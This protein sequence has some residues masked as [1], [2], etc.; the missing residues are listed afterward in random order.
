MPKKATTADGQLIL[1]LYDL[2]RESEMRKA[3]AWWASKLPQSADE[4]LAVLNNF[5]A[6]ENA[7]MRQVSGYWETAAALV[8]H[9]AVNEELFFDT[10]GEMWFVYAKIKP[11]LPELRKKLNMPQMMG[12]MEKLANKSKAGRDRLENLR[13]RFEAQRKA[14]AAK[15]S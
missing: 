14:M 2:R 12:R 13:L 15:S 1:Q 7:W 9:G 8:L 5:A 10:N 3:R 11:F 4:I 6:P